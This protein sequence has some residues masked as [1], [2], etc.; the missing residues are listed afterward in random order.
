MTYEK[1]R[2]I[3]EVLVAFLDDEL[4]C[5]MSHGIQEHLDRC[6]PCARV[7]WFVAQ[8]RRLPPPAG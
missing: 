6:E 5:D 4:P 1:C 3:K 8:R 2:E 7:A